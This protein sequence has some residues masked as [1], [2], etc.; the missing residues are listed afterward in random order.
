[1]EITLTPF[2]AADADWLVARHG[3]LYAQDEGFDETFPA[4]V[5]RIVAG[6]LADHDPV[7]EAGWIARDG[8]GQ[9]LGSIFVVAE[10]AGT[11]RLRLVLLEP[12][13]RGTGLAQR[14]LDHAMTFARR[15]GYVRMC[16]WTHE[17]HRAAGR[18][19]AR[20]GFALTASEACH[21]FGRDVVEQSWERAL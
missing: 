4:L 15:A 11:A 8:A 17:S 20:N 14:M 10:D 21:S 1:M 12:G 16:L 5:A 7:R 19:Y 6:F 2:T 9:R 13:A 18:L 3:A